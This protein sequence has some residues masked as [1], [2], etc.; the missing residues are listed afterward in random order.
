MIAQITT[1]DRVLATNLRA[2][3][4]KW[5]VDNENIMHLALPPRHSVRK[6][7]NLVTGFYRNAAVVKIAGEKVEIQL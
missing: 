6:A 1:I 4:A 7:V 3:D 5:T 2:L